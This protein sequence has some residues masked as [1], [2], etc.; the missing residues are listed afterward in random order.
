[1]DDIYFFNSYVNVVLKLITY[2]ASKL[3]SKETNELSAFHEPIE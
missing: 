3:R 2:N 1:M